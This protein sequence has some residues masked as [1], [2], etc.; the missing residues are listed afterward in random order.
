[1]TMRRTDPNGP[2]WIARHPARTTIVVGCGAVVAFGAYLVGVSLL[3]TAAEPD[4]GP[5]TFG[6]YVA[7]F[8]G[9]YP[10]L[11]VAT[12]VLLLLL[13]PDGRL[14]GRLR[15]SVTTVAL[16]AATAFAIV[17]ILDDHPMDHA[18]TPNPLGFT[19]PSPYQDV[20]TSAGVL[21][22][23]AALVV[24]IVTVPGRIRRRSPR[25]GR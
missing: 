3:G 18:G 22:L 5:L 6:R 20:L 16:A 1:M 10:G 17:Q 15:T 13:I 4:P 24:A 8:G 9:A 23:V 7:V 25:T 11:A 19:I 12:V 14:T 2:G 21:V